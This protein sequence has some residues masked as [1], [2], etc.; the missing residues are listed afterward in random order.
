MQKM[1]V[2]SIK[3]ERRD[4][5]RYTALYSYRVPLTSDYQTR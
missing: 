3:R 4:K 1:G 5:P 2:F